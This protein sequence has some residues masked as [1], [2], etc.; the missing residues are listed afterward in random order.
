MKVKTLLLPFY[1]DDAS[2]TARALKT[3]RNRTISYKD[4]QGKNIVVTAFLHIVRES[5]GKR[6]F[7]TQS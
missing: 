3:V 7:H 4:E 6:K 2:V 1:Y 5:G